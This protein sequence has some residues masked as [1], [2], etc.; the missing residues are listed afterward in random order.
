MRFEPLTLPTN[1]HTSQLS[2]EEEHI[3]IIHSL[4]AD[5]AERDCQK[6]FSQ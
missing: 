4:R 6:N 2:H 1:L 5:H 3:E